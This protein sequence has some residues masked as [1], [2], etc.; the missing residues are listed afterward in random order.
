MAPNGRQQKGTRCGHHTAPASGNSPSKK[1]RYPHHIVHSTPTRLTSA[2]FGHARWSPRHCWTR[3]A[4]DRA[5]PYPRK[6][7]LCLD[8]FLII[9]ITTISIL[10]HFQSRTKYKKSDEFFERINL[11]GIKEL[12]FLYFVFW[13]LFLG[14][15]LSK[16]WD[17]HRCFR[18]L[19]IK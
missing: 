2:E 15:V 4:R 18:K 17:N 5:V 6:E 19:V 1:T 12:W 8:W 9:R 3:H 7:I 10:Q 14:I 11:K 16:I 13:W